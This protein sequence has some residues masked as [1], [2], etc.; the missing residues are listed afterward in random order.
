M[1]AFVWLIFDSRSGNRGFVFRQHAGGEDT[2]APAARPST[3][4]RIPRRIPR[5]VEG[6]FLSTAGG[7]SSKP[8]G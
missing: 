1:G 6:E 7:V 2:R 3:A 5:N 8:A 4:L